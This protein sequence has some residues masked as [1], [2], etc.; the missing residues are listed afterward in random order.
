MMDNKL[1]IQELKAA[2]KLFYEI[3]ERKGQQRDVSPGRLQD[4][5]EEIA[6]NFVNLWDEVLLG[7][8]DNLIKNEG[9]LIKLKEI[10]EEID[11]RME[12]F[13]REEKL[14]A[15]EAIEVLRKFVITA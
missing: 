5:G 3:G 1:S 14:R 6:P 4:R 7:K 13:D 15:A 10:E 8:Y 12:Q 9:F 11:E 2:C